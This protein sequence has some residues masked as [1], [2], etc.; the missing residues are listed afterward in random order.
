MQATTAV[1]GVLT[2]IVPPSEVQTPAHWLEHAETVYATT[3]VFLT[4]ME[5]RDLYRHL[6][7]RGGESGLR[8]TMSSALREAATTS[9]APPPAPPVTA[10]TLLLCC[11][12]L[13]TLY[14]TDLFRQPVPPSTLMTFGGHALGP[15]KDVVHHPMD[16][17]TL[18]AK[19]QKMKVT[20]GAEL[21]AHV[22]LVGANCVMFN[23]PDGEYGKLARSFVHAGIREVRHGIAPDNA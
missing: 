13:E 6:L 5:C 11:G 12:F 3:G 22:L 15:Y 1:A 20:S 17:G 16:L 19:T 18:R 4:P 9:Q 8:D 14:A 10:R 23:A 21:E 2:A 7:R